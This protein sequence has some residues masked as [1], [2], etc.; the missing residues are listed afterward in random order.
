MWRW[1]SAVSKEEIEEDFSVMVIETI[2]WLVCS[3]DN[4]WILSHSKTSKLDKDKDRLV[5][6]S[7]TIPIENIVEW[8]EIK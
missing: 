8:C 1:V 5:A 6:L 7:I 3:E 4:R 2:G